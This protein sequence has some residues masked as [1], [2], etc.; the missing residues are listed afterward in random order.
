MRQY[1]EAN[2]FTKYLSLQFDFFSFPCFALDF[3]ELASNGKGIYTFRVHNQ[4]N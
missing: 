1:E 4:V 2:F 3:D